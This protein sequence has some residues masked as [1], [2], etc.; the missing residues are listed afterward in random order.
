[1]GGWQAGRQAGREAWAGNLYAGNQ[2]ASKAAR[3]RA[4]LRPAL[5]SLTRRN[6]TARPPAHPPTHP[7][8]HPAAA[9]PHPPSRLHPQGRAPAL[10]HRLQ[11]CGAGLHRLRLLLPLLL[12]GARRHL[13]GG[14]Q[15][16]THL[17]AGPVPR[18]GAQP[19]GWVRPQQQRQQQQQRQRQRQQQQARLVA[20]SWPSWLAWWAGCSRAW[21]WS[22]RP[23]RLALPWGELQSSLRRGLTCAACCA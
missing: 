16:G 3:A 12:L 8:T 6:S 5:A 22:G 2:S 20:G 17:G 14:R 1:M 18:D 7:P 11:L 13:H 23:L 10:G 19:G 21:A 4:Q 15:G 9:A